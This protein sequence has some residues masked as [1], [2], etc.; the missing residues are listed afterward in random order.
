MLGDNNVAATLAVKDLSAAQKFYGD[1]LGLKVAQEFPKEMGGVLYASGN[2]KIFV[3]ESQFAGTNQATAATWE[4]DDVEA[5]VKDLKTK[6]VTFETY[7]FLDAKIDG[8]IHR[9]E[10][11]ASAWFKDPDGNILNIS[12]RV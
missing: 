4:V 12:S 9:W 7:D 8:D 5:V 2:S 3:Y 1:T 10:N 11:Y 6:G